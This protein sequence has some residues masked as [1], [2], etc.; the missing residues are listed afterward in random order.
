[1]RVMQK[2]GRSIDLSGINDHTVTNLPLVTA[3]GVTTSQKG[4]VIVFIHQAAFM[5]DGKTILLSA[6]QLEWHKC[7]VDEKPKAITGKTPSITTLEGYKIPISISKGLAYIRLRPPNDAELKSLPKVDLTSMHEWDPKVLDST[8]KA[9][10]YDEEPAEIVNE[11]EERAHMYP[12][13]GYGGIKGEDEPEEAQSDHENDRED[14]AINRATIKAFYAHTIKDELQ[15]S[16]KVCNI[17]GILYDMYDDPD[18]AV[19]ECYP[20][21]TRA[22]KRM[23]KEPSPSSK[24]ST[25]RT[26]KK[27]RT[28]KPRRSKDDEPHGKEEH[29]TVETVDDETS[30][31]EAEDDDP[32]FFNNK[33]RNEA[34][35]CCKE[36]PLYEAEPRL[37][38]PTKED[39]G[40][41]SKYFPGT[42]HA[43]LKKTFEATTQYGTRGATQGHSLRNTILSPNPILNV[44]RR[45]E[46]VATDTLYSS[47]EAYDSGDTAT[48]DS[49]VHKLASSR[50]KCTFSDK[51]VDRL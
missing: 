9:E 37:R 16:F 24:P 27:K 45:H 46:E 26:Q 1:M 50:Y 25:G 19:Q 15:Q 20:V 32:S 7:Q 35:K 23:T 2:T 21:E 18:E 42:D 40:E 6:G 4:N 39:V 8:V 10:W 29:V 31:L 49:S 11:L 12:F 38:T 33:A 41:Y 14:R 51:S 22:Q 28:P 48:G 34:E 13:D 47:E 44:P 5:P 30:D 17:E 36:E 3:A 43:T